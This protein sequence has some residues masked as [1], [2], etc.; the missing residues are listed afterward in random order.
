MVEAIEQAGPIEQ[1]SSLSTKPPLFGTF[2]QVSIVSSMVPISPYIYSLS[3][4]YSFF[5]VHMVQNR[6]GWTSSGLITVHL[7]IYSIGV[8]GIGRYSRIEKENVAHVVYSQRTH[9]ALDATFNFLGNSV[10]NNRT[11]V[12]RL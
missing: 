10:R 9:A 12:C 8:G 11:S 5:F 3:V 7:P 6:N 2:V 4:Y 1:A